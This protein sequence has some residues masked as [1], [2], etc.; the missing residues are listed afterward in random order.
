MEDTK[1]KNFNKNTKKN[2]K[3]KN[4]IKNVTK[5]VKTP[6]YYAI[7]EGKGVKDII[8]RSWAECEKL[9]KGYPSV[10]KSFKTEEEAL[11]YLNTV[12]TELVK[13]QAKKGMEAT[14]KKRATT[15]VLSVRL[16]KDL[17][18]KFEEK[19]QAMNMT[20]ELVLKGMLEEWLI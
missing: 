2:V 11:E 7:K 3:K 4:N 5:N 18:I 16:D 20:K 15:R 9:V 17:V 14:K 10:Y 12:N 6:K 1:E 13:E 19:C 8:V